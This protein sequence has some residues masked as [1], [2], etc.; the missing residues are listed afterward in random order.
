M[1]RKR[2]YFDVVKLT[3]NIGILLFERNL[4]IMK[5]VTNNIS[6]YKSPMLSPPRKDEILIIIPSTFANG[7]SPP[8]TVMGIPSFS[9]LIAHS[10]LLETF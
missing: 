8:S 1:Q 4:S 6:T 2:E 5:P 9:D 3:K 7:Y 10:T